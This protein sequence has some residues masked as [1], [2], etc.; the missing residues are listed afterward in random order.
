MLDMLDMFD[1][2]DMFAFEIES[3]GKIFQVPKR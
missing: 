2:F 3:I 1:M